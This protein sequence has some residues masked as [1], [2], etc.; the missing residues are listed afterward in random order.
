M[1]LGRSKIFLILCGSFILGIFFSKFINFYAIATLGLFFVILL[2]VFWPSG[3]EPAEGKKRVYRLVGFVGLVF[4]FGVFRLSSVSIE[5]SPDFVG[6]F[7]GEKISVEVTVSED[8]DVR[9]GK[10]N[11]TVNPDGLRGN[12]LLNV[13]RYPEYK[14]GDR[15][16][17][18]GK[19]EEPFV[20]EEFSYKDYLSRFGVFGLIRFPQI[21][22]LDEG[23][24]N[25]LKAGLLSVKHKFQ[26]VLS[27]VLPEPH[28]AFVLGLIIGL[29]KAIPEN[30]NEAF[31]VTGVSHIVVVSGYNISI[32]TRNLLKTRGIVGRRVAFVASILV[33]LSFVV[34]T[35]A[36]ASVVRAAAMGLL[37]V[38]A[39]NIGR[40]Y[41]VVNAL[42]FIG[43]AMVL[44]NPQ[45]LRFDIGFQLSFL[46]TLGLILLSPIF[47]KWLWRVPN[48]L[49]FRTNLASTLAAQIFVLPL[50]IFYF[51]RISLVA[52]LVNV[53]VLW[54]IPYTM[55]FGF[56]IGLLGIIYL[57]LAAVFAG[58]AWILLEYMIRVV[59]IFAQIPFASSFARINLPTI[60]IFYMVLGF[61]LRYYK[62]T[63]K[64]Y[65]QLEYT[66]AKV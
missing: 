42:I 28:S 51:D 16:M 66:D 56:F 36:E 13:G 48:F 65:Q 18:S 61:W 43:A 62:K 11:L 59:E 25:I 29:K 57:P 2:T 17:I 35:G 45:I 10:V 27:Q 19:L 41:Y 39:M 14:Y 44:I 47:E 24:G 33:V 63:R 20:S 6:Q 7:F 52:P 60:V 31:I 64:F 8:P 32:I 49:Q 58:L 21:E 1:K 23:H 3:P 50:L 38:L 15:L 4:L 34:I 53:L 9:S 5:E 40:V 55:F 22:K 46:A 30:L 37:L 26:D 12:I 54:A